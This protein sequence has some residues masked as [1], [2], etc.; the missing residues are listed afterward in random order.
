MFEDFKVIKQV[1]K[2]QKQLEIE[3]DK[4]TLKHKLNDI[5]DNKSHNGL[6]NIQTPITTEIN[7]LL[8]NS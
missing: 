4:N 5:K 3:K 6:L 7:C 8:V 1:Q 2:L